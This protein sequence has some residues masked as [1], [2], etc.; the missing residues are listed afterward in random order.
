MSGLNLRIKKMLESYCEWCVAQGG[1]CQAH[2]QGCTIFDALAELAK[3]N[4][5]FEI[6][7][8]NL[9]Q[10]EVPFVQEAIK[11]FVKELLNTLTL[12]RMP[13]RN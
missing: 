13:N 11:G 6:Q 7:I 8:P 12:K 9:R 2:L 3:K 1:V 5:I 4:N 10:E